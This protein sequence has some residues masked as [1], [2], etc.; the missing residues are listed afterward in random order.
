MEKRILHFTASGVHLRSK[1]EGSDEP[2]RTIEGYAI[3]FNE[4]SGVLFEDCEATYREQIA[5]SAITRDLLDRSD[6]LMTIE[7]DYKALLARSKN[8]KGT[9]SYEIDEHG[10]RFSFEAPRTADGDKAVELVRRGDIDGCSFMFRCSYNDPTAVTAERTYNKE[11]DKTDVLYTIHAVRSIH[12][13]TLTAN[14]AYNTTS[15]EAR[16]L[17]DLVKSQTT[18]PTNDKAT[19]QVAQMRA[20]AQL[21]N[22]LK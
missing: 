10:V 17:I 2:S 4:P 13:F 18:P 11:T 8:G 14:P 19:Q 3:R 1:A 5:P 21:S 20:K 7:H 12:D 22:L 9:L 15:V 6:I 16:S